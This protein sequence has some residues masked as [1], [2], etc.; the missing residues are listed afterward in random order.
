MEKQMQKKIFWGMNLLAVIVLLLVIANTTLILTNQSIKQE[1]SN[2]QVFI[3]QSVN[4]NKLNNDI[5]RNLAELAIGK[6]DLQLKQLLNDHG[7]N[8]SI[9]QPSTGNADKETN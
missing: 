1:L 3:N 6:N 8:F 5:I 9:K 4:L 2:R 7:I